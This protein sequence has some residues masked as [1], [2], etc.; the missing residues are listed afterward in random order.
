MTILDLLI[1]KD[2]IVH[3]KS[4]VPVSDI[5]VNSHKISRI[6]HLQVL[7]K[8]GHYF[9]QTPAKIVKIAGH[10]RKMELTHGLPTLS[11]NKSH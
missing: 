6:H 11:L 3:I 9:E 1:N 2:A 8:L 5:T 7:S 4:L 10:P